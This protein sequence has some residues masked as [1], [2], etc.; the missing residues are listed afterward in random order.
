MSQRAITPT[1]LPRDGLPAFPFLAGSPWEI[2]RDE[3]ARTSDMENRF[4]DVY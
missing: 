4:P 3:Y 1:C 2:L